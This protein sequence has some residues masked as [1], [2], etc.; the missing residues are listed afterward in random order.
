VPTLTTKN[1]LQCLTERVMTVVQPKMDRNNKVIPITAGRQEPSLPARLVTASRV[2]TGIRITIAPRLLTWHV[3][4]VT[5][6]LGVHDPRSADAK[7]NH[8]SAAYEEDD[9]AVRYLIANNDRVRVLP[10]GV[11]EPEDAELVFARSEELQNGVAKWPLQRLVSIW[12]KL[13]QVKRIERFENRRVAVERIWRAI[14]QIREQFGVSR[15]RRGRPKSERI[16]K[17]EIIIGM[18]RRPDGA[19]LKSLM[20]ATE[21]QAHSVRG[22]LSGKLVK[23]RALQVK[24]FRRDGDRVYALQDAT[25]NNADV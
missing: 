15:G 7:R 13:P 3:R 21:W 20:Q 19:T 11:P 8:R 1:N 17:T 14:E 4:D 18:L 2:Q 16:N 12:N 23:Q 5:S 25:A 10:D 6:V 24:S 9:N 22:F